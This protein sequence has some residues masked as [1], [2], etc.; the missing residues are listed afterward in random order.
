M[1]LQEKGRMCK[2]VR[3]GTRRRK[4]LKIARDKR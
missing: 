1:T 2:F 3:G 4:D